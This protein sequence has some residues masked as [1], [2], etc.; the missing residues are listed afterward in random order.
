MEKFRI[1][2]KPYDTKPLKVNK[3][4]VDLLMGRDSEEVDFLTA[5]ESDKQG[6]YIISGVPGVGKTSFFNI[7]QYPASARSMSLS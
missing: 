3:C 2:R 6:V 7:M 4:D 1:Q 5:M